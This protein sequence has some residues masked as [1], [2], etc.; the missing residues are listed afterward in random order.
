MKIRS[1]LIIAAVIVAAACSKDAL[2][3]TFDAKYK[4]DLPVEVTGAKAET[5]SFEAQDTI[6]PASDEQVKQ[7]LDRIKEWKMT[8]IT[9]EFKD[10]TENFKLLTGTV[11]VYTKDREAK[12][13]FKN[14]T[15]EEAYK[16]MLDND[17]GQFDIINKILENKEAFVVK[18]MGTTDKK[19]IQ[20][21][22][23]VEVDTKV[24]ANPL[25]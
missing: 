15:V 9:G 22:L 14:I 19:D 1:L 6:D 7:Y 23:G 13:D 5:Y 20:F 25:D 4:M 16:L 2:D 3:V 10:L 24:T 21:K 12:W 8:G 17:K 18:F 11:T